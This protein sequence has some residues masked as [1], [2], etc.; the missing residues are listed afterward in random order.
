[1]YGSPLKFG[2]RF[3]KP[4]PLY[5]GLRNIF[6]RWSIILSGDSHFLQ[7]LSE[8]SSDINFIVSKV[9]SEY[10][11]ESKE[12]EKCGSNSEVYEIGQELI[13]LLN[14]FIF[15]KYE[16]PGAIKSG[17]VI[18]FRDDGKR[19][20]FLMITETI[21]STTRLYAP[22]ITLKNPDGETIVNRPGLHIFDKVGNAKSSEKAS[23]IFRLMQNGNLDFAT[24][25]K[26]V[27]ILLSEKGAALYKWVP[28]K[29][30]TLLKRTANHSA[31]IGDEARH[32]VSEE[33]PPKVP[34][35]LEEARS[36]VKLLVDK[37]I[38]ELK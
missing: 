36:I 37:Y 3:G 34:M 18:R 10:L 23:K 6:M 28:K 13:S 16:I 21:K 35:D 5:A 19:D 4:V 26:I 14:G 30:I 12:F 2:P 15:Q 29:K 7:I 17:G 1:M 31:S 22:T 8:W 38:A 25:F 33:D 9:D 11:L 24:L 32:G 20:I 27:E